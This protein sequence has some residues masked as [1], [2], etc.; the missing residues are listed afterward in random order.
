MPAILG[1]VPWGHHI[2]VITKAANPTEAIF[3]LQKISSNNWS[4]AI[5]MQQIETDLYHRTGTSINNFELTLPK[6]QIDL[7]RETLKN[8]YSFDFLGLREEIHQLQNI[9]ITVAGPATLMAILNSL[10]MG[11]RTLA[12][13]NAAAKY[14]PYPP[15]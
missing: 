13:K 7:A 9:K 4:R 6:A 8:P 14:G 5:L 12:C 3:Y 15:M 2:Q 1:Q 10:Q 11:F